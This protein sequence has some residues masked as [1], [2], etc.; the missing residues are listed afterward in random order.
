MK[1]KLNKIKRI[2][3]FVVLAIQIVACASSAK[4]EIQG[5]VSQQPTPTNLPV[6]ST[7]VL[8]IKTATLEIIIFT[9]TPDTRIPPEQWQSWPIIPEVTNRAIEIFKK[10]QAYGVNPNAFS[11]IGDCQNVK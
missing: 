1:N 2:C 7:I 3:I 5:A 8:P 11:K 6:T 9:P 10:G 4:P